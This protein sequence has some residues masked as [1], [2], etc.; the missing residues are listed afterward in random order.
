MTK[1]NSTLKSVTNVRAMTRTIIIILTSSILTS[2]TLAA[3]QNPEKNVASTPKSLFNGV[4]TNLLSFNFQNIEV[5]T[6]LQ[7]VA[8]NSGLN[9]IVSEAVKGNIT[10]NLSNVT[11]KQA[12]NVILKTQALASREF[13]NVIY[14]STIEEITENETKTLRA[15]EAVANL[16]P[17]KI[18]LIKLKYADATQI[19]EVLKG[20]QSSLLTPRGEVSVDTR[21]NSLI[22]RD[23][24]ATLAS[25][26]KS[27]NTLDVPARQVLIEARIVNVNTRFEEQL[28]VRFGFSNTRSLSGTLSGANRLAQGTSVNQ[29]PLTERLNF[30]APGQDLIG[31]TSPGSIGLALAKLGPVFIDLELSALEGINKARIIA[32]PRV[33]T[34]NQQKAYIQTGE[35]IPYQEATSSGATSVSFKKA[36]LSLTI[37]PQITPDNRIV[38]NIKAT[39]DTRGTNVNVSSTSDS[40]TTATTSSIPAIN[41]QEVQSTVLLNNNE[42]IVLGGVYKLDK[43]NRI[44]RIPFFGQLPLIGRLFSYESIKDDRQE[45]LIFLTPKIIQ[46][47]TNKP[48]VV[49]KKQVQHME[50]FGEEPK[51]GI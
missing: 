29:V 37:V 15:E 16:A 51:E 21:T 28:G 13:N 6:L 32:R 41:T 47:K 2:T 33:V 9:F 39:E 38:L 26:K 3:A 19:A 10:L 48:I 11:W 23:T 36:V 31:G 40:A 43:E 22:I 45:L 4:N 20:S 17:L 12:L 24:E 7:L 1:E 25:I 30:N 49:T 27:I 46:A 50:Y 18:T 42:T 14:I 35:E 44:D 5:R 34:S 8:K